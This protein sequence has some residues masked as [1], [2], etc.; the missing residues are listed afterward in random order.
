MIK[1]H[2]NCI[3]SGTRSPR[4]L[5]AMSYSLFRVLDDQRDREELEND[6]AACELEGG[7][8][9]KSIR[10]VVQGYFAHKKLHPFR[11]LP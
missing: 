8:L 3:K 5:E 4:T 7:L 1:V 10:T 2:K 11:I 6:D 9:G